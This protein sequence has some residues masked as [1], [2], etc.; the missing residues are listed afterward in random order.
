MEQGVAR[1]GASVTRLLFA[2][3]SRAYRDYAARVGRFLPLVGP[4]RRTS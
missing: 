1:V 4:Y 3:R 2:L